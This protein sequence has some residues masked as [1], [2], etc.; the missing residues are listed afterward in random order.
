MTSKSQEPGILFR[1]FDP[2]LAVGRSADELPTDE[3]SRH[4]LLIGGLL[5]STG[6]VLWGTLAS[7]FS[8]WMPAA[9]PYGYALLTVVNFGLLGARK[10][11]H[12]ARLVQVFISL[13]LPFLFQWSLG[14][15]MA[16][17]AAML[18]A[19]IAIVGSLTF[20]SARQSVRWL[21]IYLVLTAVSG[22]ADSFF[23]EHAPFAPTETTSTLFFTLN[24]ALI[25][26]IV[27]GLAIY[28][29]NKRQQVTRALE[30]EQDRARSLLRGLTEARETAEQA[31]ATAEEARAAAEEAARGKSLFLANM[32]HEIR[33][34]M[35]AVIGLSRLAL[36]GSLPPRERGHIEKVNLAGTALLHVLDD[37]LDL[38]KLEAR[39][40]RLE[41]IPFALDDVIAHV[42]SVIELPAAQKRLEVLV[43]Q[44]PS[45]P[46]HLIGDP[47]RLG[48][49]LVNLLTNAIKF[50]EAGEIALVF[51]QVERSDRVLL[52][53]AVRDT[54]IGMNDAQRARLFQPFTQAD[55]SMTRRY[56]GTGLGLSI[57]SR[58]VTAMGGQFE[59]ESTPGLGSTFAFSLWLDVAETPSHPTRGALLERFRS[60]RVL[61]A[62]DHDHARDLIAAR[63]H[64][65]TQVDVQVVGSGDAARDACRQGQFDL[66]LLDRVMPGL[67][68][69][70]AARAIRDEGS[71]RPK[72]VLVSADLD[73]ATVADAAA[74]LDGFLRKPV[75]RS[76]LLDLFTTLFARDVSETLKRGKGGP[77]VRLVGLRV[78]LA[79]DNAVNAEIAVE[80]LKAHGVRV[81]VVENGAEA[82]TRL[83]GPHDYDLVLMDVQMPVMDG[84]TATRELRAAGVRLPIVAM[85]AHALAEDRALALSAGMDDHLSKPLEPRRLCDTLARWC[86]RGARGVIP[87]SDPP[88]VRPVPPASLPPSP[89]PVSDRPAP[90]NP[91]GAASAH[92]PTVRTLPIL[93]TAQGIQRVAGN[94]RLYASLLRRMKAAHGGDGGALQEAIRGGQSDEALRVAHK[95]RGVVASLGA[96]QLAADLQ[97][98]ERALRDGE[99]VDLPLR[100]VDESLEQTLIA[101]ASFLDTAP[102]SGG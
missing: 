11:F 84:L 46:S 98:L 7:A 38:S 33:T 42:V 79:E 28:D 26:G 93:D 43:E 86:G 47:Q 72:I 8:L 57:C 31:R 35:N 13:L 69:L 85:T 25:S 41:Q 65:L 64:D 60:L 94:V 95:L 67:D 76:A 66:V 20:S 99:A 50:T 61:V 24:I 102:A 77:D 19:M 63:V 88:E 96:E 89:A 1:I 54:G 17:G 29:T 44:D 16:S 59:V 90:R 27:F 30:L 92:D 22:L 37:I 32:S 45:L 80:N 91:P 5:M 4:L 51:K 12:R 87:P 73:P 71:S 49:V 2:L 82:V 70:E 55:A 15:F 40:M 97:A 21:V 39:S 101:T 74:T 52:R 9:I 23:R 6:G 56:G 14:G 62:D 3:L 53:V 36:D 18:W 10:D 48:Q 58:L 100:K 75:T 81:D 34:P 83:T 78:L 68:G